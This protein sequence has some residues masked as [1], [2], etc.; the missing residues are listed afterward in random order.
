MDPEYNLQDVI[1]CHRCDNP[2][3]P[4][5]C[6]TCDTLLCKDCK[7]KHIFSGST[8]HKIVPY[9]S[10]SRSNLAQ[11][12]DLY[13][14]S[15]KLRT[16]MN[17]NGENWHRNIIPSP[18]K[19]NIDENQISRQFGSPSALSEKDGNTIP[20]PVKQNIDEHQ[21]SR[22]YGSLSALSEKDGKTI[23][24]LA[25]QNDKNQNSRQYSS[26]SALSEKD[27]N[28]DQSL[29]NEKI[30]ENRTGLQYGSFSALSEKNS[31]TSTIQSLAQQKINKNQTSRQYGSLSALSERD[32]KTSLVKQ[33]D[34]NKKK[35]SIWF[36]V[37]VIRGR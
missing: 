28:T 34:K 14:T 31:Y 13:K 10:V 29:V 20:S 22:Q 15:E 24:S 27:E 18:V 25:K 7:K 9:Q 8:E 19:Q 37:C 26:L 32:G 16:D 5:H 36:H 1:R 6:D 4:F 11:K 35:S 21:T 33:N 23:P 30:N 2:M 17:K 12:A 3:P